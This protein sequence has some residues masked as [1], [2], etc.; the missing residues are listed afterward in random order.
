MSTSELDIN[1][2]SVTCSGVVLSVLVQVR[3]GLA[4]AFLDCGTAPLIEEDKVSL[5]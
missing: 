4:R 2:N 1:V 3:F 5:Q